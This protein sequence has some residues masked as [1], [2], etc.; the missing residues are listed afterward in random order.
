M[1][2]TVGMR[3]GHWSIIQITGRTAAA[4]C[5]CGTV[6]RVA[7][8]ALVTGASTSCGCFGESYVVRTEM[9]QR[10][11]QRQQRDQRNWRGSKQ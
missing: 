6:R 8:D 2:V 9:R 1:T 4:R 11:R 3:F 7:L 10:Q 5:A